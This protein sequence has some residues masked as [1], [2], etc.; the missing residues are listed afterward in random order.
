MKVLDLQC[1]QAHVFEGW[2]ASEEDYLTQCKTA[3]IRCP[4]CGNGDVSKRLSAP[5]LNLGVRPVAQFAAAPVADSSDLDLAKVVEKQWLMACRHL[6]ENTVDVGTGF[7]DEARRIHYGEVAE[8]AIRGQATVQQTQALL[9]EGIKVL[10]VLLP[11]GLTGSF[12]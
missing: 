12:H 2:F 8:R 10:P 4:L 3:Q 9:D 6:I 11:D 5:R 1:A 7:A